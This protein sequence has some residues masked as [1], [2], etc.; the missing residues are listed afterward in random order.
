MLLFVT[1]SS[2]PV[3]VTVGAVECRLPDAT[4]HAAGL[5]PSHWPVPAKW[6]RSSTEYLIYPS[7]E[8]GPHACFASVAAQAGGRLE[9]IVLSLCMII[10]QHSRAGPACASDGRS[11]I[12]AG[13]MRHAN[14]DSGY[15]GSNSSNQCVCT[16]MT[17]C[18]AHKQI[19]F[20]A[21]CSCHYALLVLQYT[22]TKHRPTANA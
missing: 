21:R 2:G 1:Q 14:V 4:Q 13:P 22:A 18:I 11:V 19:P 9:N 17:Q 7:N 12:H 6:I 15:V 20:Q 5:H 3:D 10:G 8:F 16:G